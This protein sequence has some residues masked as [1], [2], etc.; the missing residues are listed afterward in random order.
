MLVKVI[1]LILFLAIGIAAVLFRQEI[2]AMLG[3]QSKTTTA[4]ETAYEQ[5]RKIVEGQGSPADHAK[6]MDFFRQAAQADYAPAE[7]EIAKFYETGKGVPRDP[8]KALDWYRLA[9]EQGDVQAIAGI[10]TLWFHA[11]V[12]LNPGE[13]AMWMN[14]C[15]EHAEASKTRDFCAEQLQKF[16]TNFP[17]EKTERELTE[18]KRLAA[19]WKPR[20]QGSKRPN[21]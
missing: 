14:V 19:T 20:A 21:L 4:E 9:A 7:R 11:Q 12:G 2:G 15:A 6:A 8:Q 10:M 17:G 5:G 1:A 16:A 3:I 13:A 18:G